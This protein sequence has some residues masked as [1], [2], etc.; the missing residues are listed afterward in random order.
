MPRLCIIQQRAGVQ[1]GRRPVHSFVFYGAGSIG[2]VP[3]LPTRHA[4]IMMTPAEATAIAGALLSAAQGNG[5]QI[6][7]MAQNK[8]RIVLGSNGF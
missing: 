5:R 4:W 3:S 7:S 6:T 2:N 8:I 1:T